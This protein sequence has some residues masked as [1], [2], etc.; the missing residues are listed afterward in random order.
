[1]R[2]WHASG[3]KL[4]IYS[5]GSIEAQKLLFGH[6]AF[7]DLTPLFSGFFD[8]TSGLK[9]ERAS[10]ARIAEAWELAPEGVLFLSDIGA[11]LDAAREAGMRTAQLLRPQDNTVASPGHPGFVDFNAVGEHFSLPCLAS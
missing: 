8:T 4:A 9:R 2:A 6:T 3:L 11:E 5:S 1:L 10:Y 7:G